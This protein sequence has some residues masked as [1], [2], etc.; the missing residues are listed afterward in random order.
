[1][2]RWHKSFDSKYNLPLRSDAYHV[3]FGSTVN[4]YSL[5]AFK[6]QREED[7]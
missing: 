3:K 6:T 1:M 2:E 5:V 7:I 4:D